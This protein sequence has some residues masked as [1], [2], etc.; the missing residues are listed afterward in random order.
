MLTLP[1]HVGTRRGGG[2]ALAADMQK[3]ANCQGSSAFVSSPSSQGREGGSW[4]GLAALHLTL[5]KR[6]LPGLP[7]RFR[8]TNREQTLCSREAK[9][10]LKRQLLTFLRINVP[11]ANTKPA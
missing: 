4:A 7:A 6:P 5:E 3:T 10:E 11:S 2:N 9:A 8:E 1:A